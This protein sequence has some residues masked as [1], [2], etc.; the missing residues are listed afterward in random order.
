MRRTSGEERGKSV[1]QKKTGHGYKKNNTLFCWGAGI[2]QWLERRTRD[3]EVAGSNSCGTGGTIFF[4]QDQLSVLTLISVSVPPP[5][6]R[7]ST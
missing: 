4:L 3:S 1:H 5:C 2:V 7:I 6:Y